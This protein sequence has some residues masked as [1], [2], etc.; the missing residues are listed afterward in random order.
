M[1]K[2]DSKYKNWT[3]ARIELSEAEANRLEHS[4]RHAIQR[5]KSSGFQPAGH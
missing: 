4:I 3:R 2:N 1:T 5:G